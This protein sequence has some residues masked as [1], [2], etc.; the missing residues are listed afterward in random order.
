MSGLFWIE[1]YDDNTPFPDVE[2]ALK[3]P[4]GL[5]ALGGNLS[6]KRLVEAYRKGIFPW[7]SEG[8][9][10]L[11]WSPNPRWVLFPGR[12]KVSRSLRKVLRKG[13]FLVTLDRA[14]QAV[15]YFC[16][17]PRAGQHGTWI[18]HAM[19]E[20]YNRLHSQGLAHSVETWHNGELVGGLYGVA[21]G[22]VFFG[23]SMFTR[24]R[25]ASKVALVHLVRQLEAW[26]FEL[27]DCQIRS[28]HMIS[29]GAEDIPRRVFVRLLE[30]WCEVSGRPGLW[31]FDETPLPRA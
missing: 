8:Q 28:A 22:R 14:F 18:T 23:E 12:L 21:L 15:I 9:P 13:D 25:D 20:A 2:L 19:I 30:R 3:E 11:W 17:E 24:I 29:L 27:I 1:P 31:C 5:L 10:I 4:D 7:Y 26:N 16:A 6:P